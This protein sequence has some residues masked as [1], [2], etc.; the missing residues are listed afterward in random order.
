MLIIVSDW[1]CTQC[2]LASTPPS[3]VSNESEVGREIKLF[4]SLR[5]LLVCAGALNSLLDPATKQGRYTGLLSHSTSYNHLILP[6]N[7]LWSATFPYLEEQQ[8]N[9]YLATLLP[10]ARRVS[11][12]FQ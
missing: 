9:A 5:V 3:Q 6:Y 1:S 2:T 10:C 11:A 12:W 4:P 8:P 7:E